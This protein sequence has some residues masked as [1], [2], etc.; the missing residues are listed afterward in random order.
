MSMSKLKKLG[1][2]VADKMVEMEHGLETAMEDGQIMLI[3]RTKCP[4]ENGGVTLL[5]VPFRRFYD[6]P[7]V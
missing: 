6:I 5:R 2:A 4:E 7:L 1:E 3:L